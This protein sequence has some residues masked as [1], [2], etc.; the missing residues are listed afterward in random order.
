[1]RNRL[2]NRPPRQQPVADSLPLVIIGAGASGLMAAIAATRT[3]PRFALLLEKEARAGRKLLATGNGRCNLLNTAADPA[4]YHGDTDTA[5]ALLQ[6]FPPEKLLSIFASLGLC[7]REEDEG[8]VYPASGHAGS[9]LDALRFAC[10]RQGAEIRCSAEVTRIRRERGG[11]LLTTADGASLHAERVIV[12]AGGRAA[13]SFGADG[14]AYR[15][16]TSLGH[17]VTPVFPALSPLKLPPERLRGLKGVRTNATLTLLS[18]SSPA[19]AQGVPLQTE[20]G[21][22]LF[23]DY[24]LSGLPAMALSRAACQAIATGQSV[25]LRIGLLDETA[26][27]QQVAARLCLYQDAPMEQFFTGLLHPRITLA[28][29]REAGLSPQS[30]PDPTSAAR[31]TSLLSAWTLPIQGIQP[32]EHAQVTAG[33]VPLTEFDPLTLESRIAPGLYAC[34]EALNVDGDCGGYNLM[35]AWATGWVVGEEAGRA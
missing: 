13:P 6:R 26:A 2:W 10:A 9:V 18:S 17:T 25:S 12:A 20:T 33:G 14:G 5:A 31:L 27:A 11:F 16:L 1:M 29:L 8:R 4:R 24:G 7:C 21:E 22:V 15:L 34:G 30:T 3:R 32:F 35:W 23:T 19:H 28:L